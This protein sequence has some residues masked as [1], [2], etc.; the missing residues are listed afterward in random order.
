MAYGNLTEMLSLEV[1]SILRLNFRD[2]IWFRCNK[3]WTSCIQ[4]P[5]VSSSH[6]EISAE[7]S[8]VNLYLLSQTELLSSDYLPTLPSILFTHL[9]PHA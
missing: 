5:K 6:N 4:I 8:R 3:K 2:F 1:E 7:A 9:I